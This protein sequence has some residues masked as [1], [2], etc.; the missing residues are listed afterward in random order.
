MCFLLGDAA[1]HFHHQTAAASHS[2]T[3]LF[4]PF[5]VAEPF[6]RDL[7]YP[8]PSGMPQPRGNGFVSAQQA[9][10]LLAVV[11]AT[12]AWRRIVVYFDIDF[13]VFRNP[14]PCPK[15]I[16]AESRIPLHEVL[17]WSSCITLHYLC[18]LHRITSLSQ[19]QTR[20]SLP[21]PSA[22]S[23]SYLQIQPEF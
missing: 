15:Y 7:L 9:R 21:A 1:E 11:F 19:Y 2:S 16:G 10:Q 4:H 17:L 18:T 8:T 3:S 14:T 5:A 12:P 13:Q 23:Y 6:E 22:N 20:F